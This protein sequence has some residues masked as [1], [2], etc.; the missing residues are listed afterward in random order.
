MNKR[1]LFFEGLE[2]RQ[3]LHGGHVEVTDTHVKT[4]FDTI[5]RFAANADY[6]AIASGDWSDAS[7]WYS[8]LPN[9]VPGPGSTVQIPNGITLEYDLLSDARLDAVEVSGALNFATDVDTSLWLNELMVMPEGSLTI[10]TPDAPVKDS[11]SAEIVFTDTPDSFGRHYKTGSV[12]A[13][14]VDPSQYG[15][16]LLVFGAVTIHGAEK[17]GASRLSVDLASGAS[18]LTLADAAEG[19][20]TGDVVVLPDTRETN[21]VSSSPHY[22]YRPEWETLTVAEVSGE[23]VR[24]DDP[25]EFDHTGAVNADGTQAADANGVPLMPHAVNLSRNVTLRS[26]N[27]DGVRGHTQ[28]FARARVDIRYTAFEAL[29]RTR[30]EEIDDTQYDAAGNVIHIGTN[31]AGRYSQHLHHLIGPADSD[32]E[33]EGSPRQWISVGNSISDGL[34]WGTTIH[35]AHFGELRDSVYYNIDGAAV[36]T[37]AGNEIGNQIVDNHVV[38]VNGSDQK[39]GGT[40]GT[41]D[42]DPDRGDLGDGFWFAGPMNTVEGNVVANAKRFGFMVWTNNTPASLGAHWVNIPRQPGDNPHVEGHGDRIDL[43]NTTFES[44]NGNEV[45]GATTAGI[46]I[47]DIGDTEVYPETAPNRLTNTRMWHITSIGMSAYYAPYFEIDGWTQ[48][49]DPDMIDRK[50]ADGGPSSNGYNAGISFAGN[51]ARTLVVKNADIQGM[52]RGLLN[53]GR[54]HAESL[55]MVDSHLDNHRNVEVWAWAQF[56]DDGSRDMVLRDVAFG[57]HTNPGSTNTVN[58][59]WNPPKPAEHLVP[60]SQRIENYAGI[61]G[62]DIEVYYQ[63]QSPTTVIAAGQSESLTN[64]DAYALNGQ[65]NAGSVAP[66]RIRDEDEGKIAATRGRALGINGL[67]FETPAASASL[68]PMSWVT[69]SKDIVGRNVVYFATTGDRSGIDGLEIEI[70]DQVYQTDELIGSFE[71]TNISSGLH[72][73]RAFLMRDGQRM[74]SGHFERELSLPLRTPPGVRGNQPPVFDSISSLMISANTEIAFQVRAQDPNRDAFVLSAEDLP[75]GATFDAVSGVF[76]WTPVNQQVGEYAIEFTSTDEFGQ[77]SNMFADIEVRYDATDSPQVGHWDFRVSP[78]GSAYSDAS[79]FGESA[80]GIET[81]A[82]E[83]GVT[84]DGQDAYVQVA[85]SGQ[86]RQKEEIGMVITAL[87]DADNWNTS[88]ARIDTGTWAGYEILVTSRSIIVDGVAMVQR[89][90]T[91]Q[92]L[93]ETKSRPTKIEAEVVVAPDAFDTVALIYQ[94]DES[95][96]NGGLSLYINGI[97]AAHTDDAGSLLR[98]LNWGT[99]QV[100]IG[101]RPDQSRSFS[102]TIAS[103]QMFASADAALQS[104]VNPL[105]VNGSADVS[106][107]DALSV[108]NRLASGAATTADWR[109]D[110][111]RDGSITPRDVL[112]IL[113]ALGRSALA[114][115]E[116][117][118]EEIASFLGREEDGDEAGLPSESVDAFFASIPRLQKQVVDPAF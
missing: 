17:T 21:P 43:R 10:G 117:S 76:R 36:A 31:P 52:T 105:D 112:H 70:G 44:F 81:V 94:N 90:Y 24:F 13:P 20:Q 84:F 66:S 63:E 12:D 60:Q 82:A 107:I 102:G 69:V 30:A 50:V 22:V 46:S 29:G 115:P 32:L 3:L 49:G 73:I 4:S 89:T 68:T 78:V 85:G 83:N 27:P 79:A 110:V 64:E 97:Q 77:S 25:A 47:W 56:P 98:Y 40:G 62:L 18:E 65:A 9:D 2:S 41:P 100:L 19:W 96:A 48:R 93:T 88:L 111:N 7:N 34:K 6:V 16:G 95:T 75:P 26:E 59:V 106:P 71:L 109:F 61:A 113:N 42:G 86:F 54:G 99:Q 67:A 39:F 108:I 58:M 5:P 55:M 53:R 80:V 72:S 1:T 87:P 118:G 101:G 103:V 92:I 8:T 51:A 14:G 116:T 38:R 57:E 37:E 35:G 114:L 28:F 11:V 15:N 104:A 45:Y 33:F 74:E 91:G 23:W